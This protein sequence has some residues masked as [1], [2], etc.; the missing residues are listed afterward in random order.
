MAV[1]PISVSPELEEAIARARRQAEAAGELGRRRPVRPREPLPPEVRAFFRRIL[2]DGSYA[3]AVARL[4]A[5]DP[6][7]ADQ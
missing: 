7:I 2:D 3:E 5:E 6:E 4:G 1:D